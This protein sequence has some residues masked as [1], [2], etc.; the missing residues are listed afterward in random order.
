MVCNDQ[1]NIH[2]LRK[3]RNSKPL[4]YASLLLEPTLTGL[5]PVTVTH[6]YTNTRCSTDTLSHIRGTWHHIAVSSLEIPTPTRL[7][8]SRP[9]SRAELRCRPHE[10]AN[11]RRPFCTGLSP[12]SRR[13]T[14]VA[15]SA[16]G[17]CRVWAIQRDSAFSH[18]YPV[19]SPPVMALWTTS[20]H[21]ISMRPP[22]GM[23][24][25][26]ILVL[27]TALL[28]IGATQEVKFSGFLGRWLVYC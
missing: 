26:G 28:A 6:T 27:A 20:N 24:W 10:Y 21:G 22:A 14:T 11:A 7:L 13:A 8:T 25:S 18:R 15:P 4:F 2:Y 17:L 5:T 23:E 9:T 19:Y 3:N 1:L 16:A 12:A